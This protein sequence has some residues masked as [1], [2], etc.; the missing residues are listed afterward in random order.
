LSEKLARLTLTQWIGQGR[1]NAAD[2]ARILFT[3]VD[4][5]AHE[6][7]TR[8]A[9]AVNG[10]RRFGFAGHGHFLISGNF[11]GYYGPTQPAENGYRATV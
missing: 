3:D 4:L 11:T 6:A 9:R 1:G 7:L 2:E 10:D 8:L 5:D